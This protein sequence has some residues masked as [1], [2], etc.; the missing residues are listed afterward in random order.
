MS[1]LP[2]A[3][4]PPEIMLTMGSGKVGSRRADAF[5][6]RI[7]LIA[8]EPVQMNE[9]FFAARGCRGVGHGQGNAEQGVGPEPALVRR[10]VERDQL[11]VEAGLIVQVHT[12]DGRGDFADH[13]ARRP[14]NAQAAVARVFGV[15]QLERLVPARAGARGDDRP[16]DGPC[17]RDRIDLHRRPAARVEHLAGLERLQFRHSIPPPIAFS[18]T[19]HRSSQVVGPVRRASRAKDRAMA[20]SRGVEVFDR[21][22][23]V[24]PRQRASRHVQDRHD[25]PAR[26][27]AA[28]SMPLRS[29]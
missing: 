15:A 3:C 13:V 12:Q 18:R 23:A 21:A 2:P 9:Q 29:R 27:R 20:C 7:E 4:R 10:A 6:D 28:V 1:R 19:M 25:R 16:A 24:D 22:L 8:P 14:A 17:R 26:S 11:G 5:S